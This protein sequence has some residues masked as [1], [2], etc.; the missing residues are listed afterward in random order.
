MKPST[1]GDSYTDMSNS[2]IERQVLASARL[3]YWGRKASAPRALRLYGLAGSFIALRELT[4]LREVASNLLDVGGAQAL[5]AFL[6][7]AFVN[8]EL[9]VQAVF[10]V[11]GVLG[12]LALRDFLRTSFGN[13]R[14]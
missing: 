14:A 10:L 4:F 3:I 12:A 7:D 1:K 13:I 5:L 6:A 9:A 11:T 2:N 8:T